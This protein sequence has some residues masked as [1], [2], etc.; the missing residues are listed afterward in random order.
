M[1]KTDF[2][3]KNVQ[4]Y[5]DATGVLETGNALDIER[6]RQNYRKIY[7]K[8]YQAS[9]LSKHYNVTL[10]FSK[11]DRV[12][13][14]RVAT[15]NGKPLASFI[16]EI[17]LSH[18]SGANSNAFDML[19]NLVEIKRLISLSYDNVEALQYENSYPELQKD[20]EKL[21]GLFNQIEILLK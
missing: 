4:Q 2:L 18:L 14:Q 11:K 3:Y 6:A 20:Y 7:Q 5:L 16:K 1:K 21:I 15:E 9:Y 19:P 12:L 13:L 17:A 8:H 10:S